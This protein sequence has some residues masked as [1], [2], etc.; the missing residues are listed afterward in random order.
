V[1][2]PIPYAFG[3]NSYVFTENKISTYNE[4]KKWWI[5]RN[6]FILYFI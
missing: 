1:V 6:N 3:S 5:S 4:R 2:A